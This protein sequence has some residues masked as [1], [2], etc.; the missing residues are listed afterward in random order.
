[1]S[2][3]VGARRR[4]SIRVRRGDAATS[5]PP[6]PAIQ[7]GQDS[8]EASR[9]V[10]RFENCRSYCEPHADSALHSALPRMYAH[11]WAVH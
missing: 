6:A 1:M 9:D 4:K 5:A 8:A 2:G 3:E 11:S 7:L 10:A